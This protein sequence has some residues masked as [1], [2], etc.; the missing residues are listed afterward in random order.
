MTAVH[1][2]HFLHAAVDEL[3]VGREGKPI[4]ARHEHD[5]SVRPDLFVDFGLGGREQLLLGGVLGKRDG[6]YEHVEDRLRKNRIKG[7][8]GKLNQV[9]SVAADRVGVQRHVVKG[10][11]SCHE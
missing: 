8:F 7:R 3:A 10:L 1:A 2:G 11:G 9:A 6:P 4:A 5:R